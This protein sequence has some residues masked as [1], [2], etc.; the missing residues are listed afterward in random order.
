MGQYAGLQFLY[1]GRM[2]YQDFQ[3]RKNLS[4]MVSPNV[5]RSLEWVWEGSKTF[6]SE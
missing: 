3:M 1:F 2:D 6:G 5:P 4:S